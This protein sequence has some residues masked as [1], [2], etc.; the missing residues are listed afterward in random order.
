MTGIGTLPISVPLQA[1]NTTIMLVKERVERLNY[2]RRENR[3]ITMWAPGHE[4]IDCIETA[5][6]FDWQNLSKLFHGPEPSLPI[7]AAT[8]KR[9]KK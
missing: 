8:L 7:S 4:G 9:D 1:V 2:V 6:S 5:N 3:I